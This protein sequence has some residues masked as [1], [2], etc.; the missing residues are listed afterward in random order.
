MNE[1]MGRT[2]EVISFK[3]IGHF[4]KFTQSVIL[5]RLNKTELMSIWLRI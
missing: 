3:L 1:Y 2:I 5:G 4:S